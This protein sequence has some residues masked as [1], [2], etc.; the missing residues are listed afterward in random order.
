V[1][2]EKSQ[3]GSRRQKH[4]VKERGVGCCILQQTYGTGNIKEEMT[5]G[6][7]QREDTGL[8]C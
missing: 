8:N 3:L 5:A 1:L 6:T 7:A 4:G 2:L